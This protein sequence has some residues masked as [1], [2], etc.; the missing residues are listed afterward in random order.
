MSFASFPVISEEATYIQNTGE[1]QTVIQ[2]EP[3]APQ[4]VS[5]GVF[6]LTAYCPCSR[7]CGKWAN[8]ITASGKYA[9]EGRTIAVDRRQIPLGTTVIIDGHE[10][11]AEDVGGAIKGN[12]I[13]VYF[14]THRQALNFGVQY[15]EVFVYR[16]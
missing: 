2:Q 10:Y 14:S 3:P 12:R 1:L 7:C 11:V 8:G 4:L 9:Q 13:D 16:Q 15:K 5:L 6:K